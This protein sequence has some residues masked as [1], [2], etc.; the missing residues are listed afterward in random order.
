MTQPVNPSAARHS[1]FLHVR[2]PA[3][4]LDRLHRAA[5]AQDRPLSRIVR[6][7]LANAL[8]GKGERA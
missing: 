4:M 7:A 6:S 2:L 8:D 1:A 5:A 3:E